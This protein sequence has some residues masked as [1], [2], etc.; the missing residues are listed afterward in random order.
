MTIDKCICF[1]LT[2]WVWI[3]CIFWVGMSLAPRSPFR[4]PATRAQD[5]LWPWLRRLQKELWTRCPTRDIQWSPTSQ[6]FIVDSSKGKKCGLTQWT[7]RH[8]NCME[9]SV[10]NWLYMMGLPTDSSS[11]SISVSTFDIIF[12]VFGC[13]WYS[14]NLWMSSSFLEKNPAPWTSDLVEPRQKS[15]QKRKLMSGQSASKASRW[16]AREMGDL[17]PNR[18]ENF[19]VHS[20]HSQTSGVIPTNW[21]LPRNLEDGSLSWWVA[22]PW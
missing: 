17:N 6:I 14:W 9:F 7:I 16:E 8:V 12:R 10:N 19:I 1:T 13:I 11:Y 5:S 21:L 22:N 4:S 15:H 3:H 2:L 18:P 20:I